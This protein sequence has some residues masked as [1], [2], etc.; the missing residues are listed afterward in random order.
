MLSQTRLLELPRHEQIY[1]P[2]HPAAARL[3]FGLP[4]CHQATFVR[5]DLHRTV[6]HD[7]GYKV[8]SDYYTIAKMCQAGARTLGLDVALAIYDFGPHN[9][10]KR[11]TLTRF[12]DFIAVQRRV[13]G[14]G[15]PEVAINTGRL[16]CV[17][18]A[19]LAIISPG[20]GQ[21]ISPLLL[22]RRR[23]QPD[24]GP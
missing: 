9:L 5:R 15:W 1:R 24:A 17:H 21:L 19:Y 3:R 10:S 23:V 20:L 16:L 6:P 22:G 14:K 7:L 18:W 11:A 8:S 13:L 4:A 2:P 12:R